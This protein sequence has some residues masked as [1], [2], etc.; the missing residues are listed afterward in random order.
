MESQGSISRATLPTTTP[1]KGRGYHRE[2]G[3]RIEKRKAGLRRPTSVCGIPF[4]I[5]TI[6]VAFHSANGAAPRCLPLPGSE[7][8]KFEGGAPEPCGKAAVMSDSLQLEEKTRLP[9]AEYNALAFGDTDHD[10]RGEVVLLKYIPPSLFRYEV[11]ENQGAHTYSLEYSGGDLVPYATGD[12]DRDGKAE[13]IGQGIDDIQVY[14]SV[15]AVSYPTELVW[16][17][18]PLANVVGHTTVG[19][20]DLDGRMEIIHSVNTFGS[21]A[22]VIFENDGDNSFVQVGALALPGGPFGE[23]AIGDLDKDGIPEIAFSGIEGWI[24]VL[25]TTGNNT[26]EVKWSLDTDLS[27]AYAAE[28]GPD[29]DGNGKCELFVSGT[30][31]GWR[32]YVYETSGP[33]TYSMVAALVNVDGYA[34]AGH[35]A[36]GNLTGSGRLLYLTEGYCCAWVYGATG[37]GQWDLVAMLP[38]NEHNGLHA[39]DLNANGRSEVF[40][41]GVGSTLVLEH[42]AIWSDVANVYS[43]AIRLEVSPN[44]VLSSASIR[45]V[46]T[47]PDARRLTLYDVAGRQVEAWDL[48]QT[49]GALIW[50]P[51]AI[52]G[53]VYFLRLEGPAGATV[54]KGRITVVR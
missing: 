21:G 15:D 23:K 45:V 32:T 41:A 50:R 2:A 20:T 29:L 48:G 25:E 22:I 1:S 27:N 3:S 42:S 19:D 34:G 35:N 12:L 7:V 24:H 38:D 9:G 10:G 8:R 33:D 53:G 43:G 44:P 17:S 52:G 51:P 30:R 37:P 47:P 49:P 26:W 54:A 16:A 39:N 18:P 46:G 11:H 6:L 5:V 4:L 13:I 40:W 36:I 28:I 31:A 14:E